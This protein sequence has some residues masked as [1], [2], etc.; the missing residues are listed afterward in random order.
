[1]FKYLPLLLLLTAAACPAQAQNDT[2]LKPVFRDS[3]TVK[4]HPKYN[5]NGFIHTA[6]FGKNY[7]K[8]WSI[9]VK[10]PVIHISEIYGGLTIT[11]AGGG[12]QTKSVR[13][14]D[15]NGKEYQLRTVEKTPDQV[16]PEGLKNTFA[17]DWVRDALSSQHPFSALAVPPMAKAANIPHAH[18]FIGVVA[19][20]KALGKYRATFLNKVCLIEDREPIGESDN[21]IKTLEKL[22][23]DNDNRF[24]GDE[25]MRARLLDLLIGDW[26]RHEDQWRWADKKQGD[27]KFYVAVPRD[28]DQAFHVTE[29]LIPNVAASPSVAPILGDFREDIGPVKY[30]YIKTKFINPF[31][32]AQMTHE[33]W[34]K[35][36]NDFVAAETDDVLEAG[37]KLMPPE[38][39]NLRHIELLNILK[40]RRD[41][42]PVK[43]D[44]LYKFLYRIVDV[45]A[46]KKDEQ[47]TV[48][49]AP[50]GGLQVVFNKMKNGKLGDTTFFVTYQPK[51]T[52]E[53]RLYTG[54]GD[55][56]IVVNAP[57]SAIDLRV[58][59]G[60]GKTNYDIQAAKS[61]VRIYDTKEA[62]FNG[63]KDKMHTHISA[64]TINTK[65]VQTNP[66]N[67]LEP[68]ATGGLNLDDGLLIG[69]GLKY[70]KR[71]GFRKLPYTSTQQ[72][73]VTHAFATEA[74]RIRYN[75]EFIQAVGKADL[76]LNAYARA[77][78]NT[79]NF[80][81][82]GNN[83][84]INKSQ[85]NYKR[86]YRTRF[87]TYDFDAALRWHT[88]KNSSISAGPSFQFYHL[89]ADDNKGRLISYVSQ[90]G[91]YDS[92]IVNKD[93]AHLGL[94][95]NFN[96]NQRTGGAMLPKGGYYL[97]VLLEGYN[98]LNGYSK[99]Y[100][101]LRPEITFYQKI[102][103]NGSVVLSDRIGGGISIGKPAFYQSMFLGGNGNLLGYLQNRFAGKHMIYNNLQARAKLFNVSSYILP[104]ELGLTGFYDAGRVWSEKDASD[105]WHSG[106]GGGLYFSPAGLLIFQVLA[107]HSTE[108]WY[109]YVSFNVRI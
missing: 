90:I 28:R 97:N 22:S 17:L 88:G 94:T 92:L 76:L 87:D 59:G 63:S 62:T 86:F 44:E 49:D 29:G 26:D 57:T 47:V 1:M 20:D 36:T 42:L 51:Y 60:D 2:P 45:R 58:I 53:V 18:P 50:E 65:F 84:P 68:I 41:E 46:T 6:F 69:L 107:G 24:D 55:D 37:L 30:W 83:T 13:L 103:S 109:P 9:P 7:R 19:D 10:L 23:K 102:T 78:D 75:G 74:F 61:P 34:M 56:R 12:E 48:T 100:A 93:K 38:I 106:V 14:V 105:K 108:G 11:Q 80:F 73:M 31:P 64:D 101:Q 40:K 89:N 5:R 15:K 99:S 66:Y 79:T 77:P 72:L 52:R 8:E 21:T 98:G 96:S 67:L 85:E 104:G 16:L 71:D 54:G 4:V 27:G 33:R 32:D 43:M 82:L 81:G 91:S 95:V 70:T 35:V 39:Y 25:F 3:V